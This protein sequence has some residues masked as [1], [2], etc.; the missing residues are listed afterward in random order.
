MNLA[1]AAKFTTLEGPLTDIEIK[2]PEG[3]GSEFYIG[4][5][6]LAARGFSGAL[7]RPVGMSTGASGGAELAIVTSR[8]I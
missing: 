2:I 3:V 1:L 6:Y 5:G 4:Q 8:S 7:A